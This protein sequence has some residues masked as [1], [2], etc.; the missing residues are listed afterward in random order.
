MAC[1]RCGVEVSD[2]DLCWWCEAALCSTCWETVGHCGH[3][4]AERANTASR[5]LDHEG[6]R[7]LIR[8]GVN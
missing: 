8:I 2:P 6:R 1:G 5:M 7:A 3:E 4:E